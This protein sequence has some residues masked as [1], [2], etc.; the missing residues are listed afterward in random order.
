MIG[1]EVGRGG[2]GV[3]YQAKELESGA[4]F[5][6]KLL[7]DE[8]FKITDAQRERFKQEI[9]NTCTLESEYIVKGVDSGERAGEPFMVMEWMAGKTLQKYIASTEYSQEDALVV[10]SRLLKALRD[11]HKAQLVHRDIKPN[12]VLLSRFPLAKLADLG[13][14]KG[15]DEAHLTIAGDQLGSLL[16]ISERQRKDPSTATARDDFYASCLVMYEVAAKGRRVHTR[17]PPVES[18]L[19]RRLPPEMCRLIDLGMQ[20]REDWEQIFDDMC[21]YLNLEWDAVNAGYG[22]SRYLPEVA[23]VNPLRGLYDAIS[24]LGAPQPV[25]END[26]LIVRVLNVVT[27]SF[28]LAASQMWGSGVSIEL[29]DD[30]VV[31][32][33][34]GFSVKFHGALG[35]GIETATPVRSVLDEFYGIL[36]FVK[37]GSG[38]K[39]DELTASGFDIDESYLPIDYRNRAITLQ[40]PNDAQF[41]QQ[42]G[43]GLALGIALGAITRANERVSYELGHREEQK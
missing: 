5:A 10:V 36:S 22:G 24:K 9:K 40:G 26:E 15:R 37:V 14:A 7:H 27:T 41:L 1:D 38:Y 17:N 20:D 30:G 4:F 42:L 33:S 21:S 18:L 19:D 23:L 6:L 11:L 2:V 13:V 31:D 39:V 28:E 8:R 29:G 35:S 32:H 12:N 43:A 25:P 16:Y 3:V 34:L